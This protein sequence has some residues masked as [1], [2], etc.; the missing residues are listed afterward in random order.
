MTASL[1]LALACV[2]VAAG[3]WSVEPVL[4]VAPGAVLGV[5]AFLVDWERP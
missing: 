5:L 4:V 3:L 2:I 1:L